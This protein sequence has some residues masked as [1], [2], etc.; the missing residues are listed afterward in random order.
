MMTGLIANITGMMESN[1]RVGILTHF[2][3]SNFGANLQALSTVSYLKH[4]GFDPVFISWEGYQHGF[5]GQVP[6][7]QYQAHQDFINTHLSYTKPCVTDEEIRA[8]ITKE[9]ITSIIVGSDAVLTYTPYADRFYLTKK[10]IRYIKP[11]ADYLFPNPHWLSFFTDNFRMPAAMMSPSSQ[12]SIFW[13]IRG[14]LRKK[15]GEHLKRFSYYTARDSWTKKMI[16]YLHP[17][18]G[19]IPVTPDPVLA[20]NQNFPQ[21]VTREEVLRKF[22]LPEKYI[23][24]SFHRGNGKYLP[25]D[26]WI[27]EFQRLAEKK[28]LACVEL[29]MPKGKLPLML[30]LQI[31][32]PLDPIDW[33]NLIRFSN[34]Y[35]GHNMHPII[36]SVHNSSP[37]FAFDTYGFVFLRF[38]RDYKSSKIYDILKNAGLLA[39]WRKAEDISKT[40][41]AAV[42][43]ALSDFDHDGCRK[44][45]AQRLADYNQMMKGITQDIAVP[46]PVLQ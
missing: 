9:H 8:V 14:A 34:G 31:D 24:L 21:Q 3:V 38:F 15:M 36:V 29:P 35:V 26:A 30:D 1:R 11:N 13:L 12:N 45:A 27:A 4:H 43:G 42:L 33:Y 7:A 32:M 23:L 6:K 19:D 46:E 10:G 20:F 2:N 16:E 28:G 25:S 41:P 5:T 22:N 39:N 44:F 40:P 17:A 37:F 18:V